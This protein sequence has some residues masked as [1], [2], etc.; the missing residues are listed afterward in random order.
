MDVVGAI[1]AGLK[2]DLLLRNGIAASCS[3]RRA[4]C[5]TPR[6]RLSVAELMRRE[7]LGWHC[8]R[9]PSDTYQV[10]VHLGLDEI[11]ECQHITIPTRALHRGPT[12]SPNKARLR[13]GPAY[14]KT[15]PRGLTHYFHWHEHTTTK[16]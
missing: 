5:P 9:Y 4:A 10:Q 12:S 1:C 16:A 6:G 15:I 11:N 8:E 14:T 2:L 13:T 7:H 3:S